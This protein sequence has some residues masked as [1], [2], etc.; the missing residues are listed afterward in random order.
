MI[1]VVEIVKVVKS[2]QEISETLSGSL[3]IEIPSCEQI[4]VSP[5]CSHFLVSKYLVI[6]GFLSKNNCV[7]SCNAFPKTELSLAREENTLLTY[8]NQLS[9][10]NIMLRVFHFNFELKA[11]DDNAIA[12]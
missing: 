12:N 2:L 9:F 5:I 7:A 3:K 1:R 4:L 10:P 8:N 11:V 6:Y